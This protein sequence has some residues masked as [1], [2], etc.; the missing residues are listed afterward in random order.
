MVGFEASRLDELSPTRYTRDR[1]G[2]VSASKIGKPRSCFNHLESDDQT[3]R[4]K[5]GPCWAEI[6]W[7]RFVKIIQVGL[8]ISSILLILAVRFLSNPGSDY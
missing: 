1:F 2:P 3:R 5:V 8:V 4:I 6:F 7:L